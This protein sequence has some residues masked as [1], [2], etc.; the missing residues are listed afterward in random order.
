[1]VRI[2]YENRTL[3][4]RVVKTVSYQTSP[5]QPDRISAT[6]IAMI[7][8]D[9]GSEGRA[10]VRQAL[11]TAVEAGLLET[12]G[13]DV[14]LPEREDIEIPDV[15]KGDTGELTKR[16]KEIIEEITSKRPE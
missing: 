7:L 13:D 1:M 11:D 5:Q 15:L 16:G 3:V 6:K 8:A 2:D 9:H 4:G 12:D 14:W 10:E